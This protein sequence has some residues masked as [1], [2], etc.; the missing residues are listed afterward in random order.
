[1]H[2]IKNKNGVGIAAVIGIVTFVLALTTTLFGVTVNQ[3]TMI[4]KSAENAEI[5]EKNAQ[6][7][8]SAIR[9]IEN[10]PS[11]LDD[12]LK[13][14]ALS[15]LLEITIEQPLG[16]NYWILQNNDIVMPLTSYI[17]Y[18]PPGSGGDFLFNEFLSDVLTPAVNENDYSIPQDF[19]IMAASAFYNEFVVANSGSNPLAVSFNV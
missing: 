1:M 9:I 4:K 12:A 19:N 3:A 15:S 18:I 10:D 6:Y 11:I 17:Q 2:L 8:T 14:S 7:L 16:Q 5:Y 13:I